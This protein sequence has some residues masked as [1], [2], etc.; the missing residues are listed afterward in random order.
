MSELAALLDLA[1]DLAD[2]AG[3]LTLGHFRVGTRPAWKADATPVTV[4]DRE[5]E[6]LIRHELERRHPDHAVVGEE[7]GTTEGTAPW[8]WW[9][10][11]IDGTKSFVRGVPL[12]AV[13]IGLE[14]DGDMVAGVA[15]FPALQE[16]LAAGEGLGC[17]LNGRRCT[18]SDVTDLGRAVVAT[19]DPGAFAAHGREAAWGRVKDAFWMRTGWGDAYGYALVASGRIEAMLDPVM[20][21]WDAG[22]F[23]AILAEAGGSFGDWRGR[24]GIHHG[25]GM[26]VN[27]A[28]RA[29]LLDL[30]AEDGAQ[31]TE[32]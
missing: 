3:R 4:A 20:N 21:P 12:Y 9:I 13:L 28:L 18:V 15:A 10:D 7:H 24:P 6:T 27:A 17:R 26:A 29:P 30:L 1:V 23:P 14:R 8:R 31:A 32:R 2:R 25:E 16:T 11:P 22:P 19:T 5:A